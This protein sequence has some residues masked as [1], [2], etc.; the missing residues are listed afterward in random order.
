M[1]GLFAALLASAAPAQTTWIVDDNPGPGVHFTSLPAAVAAAAS[2]DTL[3]VAPGHY[4]PFHVTGKALTILGDGNVTTFIDGSPIAGTGDYVN[5]TSPPVGTTFRLSGVTIQRDVSGTTLPYTNRL[6]ISGASV[7]T[8]GTVVLTDVRS[9]PTPS[10]AQWGGGFEAGLNVRRIAVS[11]SRCLFQG[12]WFDI[13]VFSS[14]TGRAGVGV[15]VGTFVADACLISGGSP[16]PAGPAQSLAAGDGL[17]VYFATVHLTGCSVSGGSTTGAAST[18]VGGAGLRGSGNGIVRVYG[19]AANSIRGGNVNSPG[20]AGPGIEVSGTVSVFGPVVV[21][22]GMSPSGPAPATTGTGQVQLG[23]P[24][25]PVLS[26]TGSAPNGGD[27]QPGQPVTLSLT[28]PTMPSHLF[29][30]V[31]DLAPGYF[32]L[33]GI[34]PEPGLLSGAATLLLAGVLDA[35][36]Q[37]AVTFTPATQAPATT[38]HPFHLQGFVFDPALGLWL[39][40]NAEVRRIR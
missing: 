34:S 19:S 29:G 26:L 21:A 17:V 23:L 38:H 22:G 39:G 20:T 31:I 35:A 25:R 1:R 27:L 6:A 14:A 13:P 5:I 24:P 40:S 30:L 4:E 12:A 36:G 8:A 18:Q 10:G 3:L 2:G 7:S 33:P 37:F 9:E 15:D 28:A 11:A 32:A 16:S